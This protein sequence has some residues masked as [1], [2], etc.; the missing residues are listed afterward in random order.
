MSGFAPP[1][2]PRNLNPPGSLLDAVIKGSYS[3]VDQFITEGQD[4]NQKDKNGDSPLHLAIVYGH[5]DIV[6]L[7][8]HKG[9][10]VSM[11][12]HRGDTPVMVAIDYGQSRALEMLLK[13]GADMDQNN[14]YNHHPFTHALNKGR[15]PEI[16][17]MLQDEAA[18]RR[19]ELPA[20]APE[21]EQSDSVG[22]RRN[23]PATKPLSFPKK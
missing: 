12:G 3:W 1:P 5:T 18:R 21:P 22:L 16:V 20:Q 15:H 2:K 23:L 17:Q 9:A 7:L 11:K 13:K 14:H 6:R 4:I 19:G 10:D 8:I